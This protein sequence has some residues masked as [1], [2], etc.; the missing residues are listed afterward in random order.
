MI[1]TMMGGCL[2]ADPGKLGLK[3]RN[4][5][6]VDPKT[7]ILCL[8]CEAVEEVNSDTPGVSVT[9]LQ[10]NKWY[11]LT[12]KEA[13]KFS[14]RKVTYMVSPTIDLVGVGLTRC[15]NFTSQETDVGVWFRPNANMNVS[16]IQFHVQLLAIEGVD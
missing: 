1:E 13:I 14:T 15:V 16:D 3:D 12:P 7:Y 6:W 8:R 2:R 4:N 5:Y 9:Q 10:K 11:F